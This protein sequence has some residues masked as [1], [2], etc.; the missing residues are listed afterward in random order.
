M[1][2]HKA[3]KQSSDT[4]LNT[5]NRNLSDS[6]LKYCTFDFDNKPSSIMVSLKFSSPIATLKALNSLFTKPTYRTGMDMPI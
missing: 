5:N 6:S 4:A 3:A 2:I 1:R